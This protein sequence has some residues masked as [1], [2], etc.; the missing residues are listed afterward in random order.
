MQW[1]RYGYILSGILCVLSIWLFLAQGLNYGIDFKGGSVLTIRTQGV[2]NIDDIRGKLGGLGL[3]DVEVQEF[4]GPSDVLI[5]LEAQSGGEAA[6]L[7]AQARSRKRSAPP[8][9]SAALKPW[10]PKSPMS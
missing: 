3:G 2:A 7:A 10:V 1:S 9:N 4:G 5:R 8:S 6:E